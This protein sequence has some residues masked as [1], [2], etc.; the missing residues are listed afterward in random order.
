MPTSLV[1]Y[2]TVSYQNGQDSKK[3][4]RKLP[5]DLAISLLGICPE[6]DENTNSKRSM[7]SNVHRCLQ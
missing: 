1:L 6:K 4:K 7:N 5:H 2:I 3:L